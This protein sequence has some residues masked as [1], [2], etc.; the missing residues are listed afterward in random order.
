MAG[1]YLFARCLPLEFCLVPALSCCF[2]AQ[3]R[4]VATLIVAYQHLLPSVLAK[5]IDK[6]CHGV[7]GETGWRTSLLKPYELPLHI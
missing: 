5:C 2:N 3:A 6:T 7:A 4:S 1:I